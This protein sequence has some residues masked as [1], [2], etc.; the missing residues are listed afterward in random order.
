MHRWTRD[1][2]E[3]YRYQESGKQPTDSVI[4]A[5]DGF[6]ILQIAMLN[7]VGQ[8]WEQQPTLDVETHG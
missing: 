1:R 5:V 4:G 6:S 8:T 2:A 7:Y 3:D